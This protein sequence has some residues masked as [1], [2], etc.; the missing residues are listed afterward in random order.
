VGGD[1]EAA[2]R[3]FMQERL[4]YMRRVRIDKT[5][6]QTVPARKAGREFDASGPAAAYHHF[7]W[8]CPALWFSRLGRD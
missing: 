7:W 8:T 1:I 6:V 2:R 5:H 4:P 3:N